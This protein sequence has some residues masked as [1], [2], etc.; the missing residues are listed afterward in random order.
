MHFLGLVLLLL[1]I[2]GGAHRSIR[3]GEYHHGAQHES[4]G[5]AN[6]LD[7]SGESEGALI[8]GGF[9]AGFL[10]RGAARGAVTLHGGSKPDGRRSVGPTGLGWAPLVTNLGV[11]T[12][13]LGIAALGVSVLLAP[14]GGPTVPSLLGL[15][16]EAA[17]PALL[18]DTAL[19]AGVAALVLQRGGVFAHDNA[20]RL[21]YTAAQADQMRPLWQIVGGEARQSRALAAL[22]TWQLSIALAEELYYRGFVQSGLRFGLGALLVSGG[23]QAAEGGQPP[24]PL[25]LACEAI[26]LIASSALFGLVHTEFV[27]ESTMSGSKYDSKEAWFRETAKYGALYGLLCAI[28]DHQLLAPVC[29]HAGMNIGLCLRDWQRLRRTDVDDLRELFEGNDESS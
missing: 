23:F 2:T 14:F 6:G 21:Q 5:F 19:G 17:R 16:D 26:A 18:A 9:G 29:A 13:Y 15:S 3:V 28:T 12:L 24:L 20:S 8:P 11:Q 10:R 22:A 4:N 25:A 7:V 1:F 27:Q